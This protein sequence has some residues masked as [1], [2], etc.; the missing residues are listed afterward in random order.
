M[1]KRILKN[2]FLLFALMG[3][4]SIQLN[5]QVSG[6]D[7]TAFSFDLNTLASGNNSVELWNVASSTWS[8]STEQFYSTPT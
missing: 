7:Q 8:T 4:V 3:L 1:K 6:Y 5:A 2:S